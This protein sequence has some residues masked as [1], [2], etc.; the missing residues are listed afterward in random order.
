MSSLN[1]L[2]LNS[3]WSFIYKAKFVGN[4]EFKTM[5][6]NNINSWVLGSTWGDGAYPSSI[7]VIYTIKNN[8]TSTGVFP[9]PSYTTLQTTNMWN[10]FYIGFYHVIY[11]TSG[12]QIKSDFYDINKNLILSMSC[13][14]T[15]TNNVTPFSIYVQNCTSDIYYNGM[16]LV[17]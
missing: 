7:P 6:D 17:A 3:T 11:R 4:T 15:Y 16:L 10:L 2:N 8:N 9:T 12:G 5:F 13:N 14:Y 1:S